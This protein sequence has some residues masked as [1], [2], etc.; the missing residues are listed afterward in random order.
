MP[1]S[2]VVPH[3]VRFLVG[4][5]YRHLMSISSTVTGWSD[6][7]GQTV[8]LPLKGDMPDIVFRTLAKANGLD[9]DRD[10]TLQYVSIDHGVQMF[11]ALSLAHVGSAVVRKGTT[12]VGKHRRA[13]LFFSAALAYDPRC[14]PLALS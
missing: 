2:L 13:A 8:A 5:D 11:L 1:V 7:R 14:C 12:N 10:L 9:P 4:V 6:L 3:A